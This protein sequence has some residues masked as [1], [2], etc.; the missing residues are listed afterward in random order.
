MEYSAG[1]A[2]R[3][4]LKYPSIQFLEAALRFL[5]LEEICLML[6]TP[7]ATG[8]IVPGNLVLPFLEGIKCFRGASEMKPKKMA[9]MTAR[10]DDLDAK[11][12]HVYA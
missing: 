10:Y 8:F 3:E 5:G 11:E 4:K 9:D 6:Q 1:K 2:D 7:L 12:L